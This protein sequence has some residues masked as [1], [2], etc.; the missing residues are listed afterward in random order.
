MPASPRPA[1]TLAARSAE[2]VFSVEQDIEKARE[3]Y[4]DLKARAS[5]NAAGRRIRS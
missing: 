5:R 3:F 2:V 1:A 4:A